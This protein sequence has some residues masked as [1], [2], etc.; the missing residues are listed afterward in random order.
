MNKEETVSK[1]KSAEMTARPGMIVRV[2][3]RVDETFTRDK[4]EGALQKLKAGKPPRF[5]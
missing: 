3:E 5:D 1:E 2:F 4:M